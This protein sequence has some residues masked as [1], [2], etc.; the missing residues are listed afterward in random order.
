MSVWINPIFD[1]TQADVDFASQKIAEW[2]AGE[3][4]GTS[5]VVYDL[6]GCLNVSDM[7]RIEGNI[8]YLANNFTKYYYPT[9][10][11][12]KIWEVSSMPTDRD[13]LR[14]LD[15][16]RVLI[17]AFYKPKNAPE[18]PNN[19]LNYAEINNIEK[20]LHLIKELLDCMVNSFRKSNTLQSGGTMFLPRQRYEIRPTKTVNIKNGALYVES[21]SA[22]SAIMGD[23]MYTYSIEET[24][25]I[26]D[27]I[28]Y[29]E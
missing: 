13:V 7:N 18:V 8:A 23:V 22:T 2:I 11:S 29:V 5:T 1:R 26:K 24:A 14:I 6:K 21:P 20:N 4:T 9:N 16:V 15:N 10:V 17:N 12:T 3:V 27:D 25:K 19:M 28:L